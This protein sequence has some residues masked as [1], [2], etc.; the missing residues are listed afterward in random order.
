VVSYGPAV[1]GPL[2]ALTDLVGAAEIVDR[3]KRGS[4][5]LVTDWRRRYPDFPAPVLEL[6]MGNLWLWP[7]VEAWAKAT[8]RL[9]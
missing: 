9:E 3:L 2:V 6:S 1:A 5:K 4:P 8:G 7:E